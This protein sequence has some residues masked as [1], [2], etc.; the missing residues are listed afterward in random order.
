MASSSG[1]RRLLITDDDHD[2]TERDHPAER[3]GL[4][5][6]DAGGPP[7]SGSSGSPPGPN[8]S[9]VFSH[10]VRLSTLPA[11]AVAIMANAIMIVLVFL[12]PI[13]CEG[14]QSDTKPLELCQL[15]PFSILVYTHAAHWV[16][17][18][19]VDQFLKKEH[20]KSRLRGYIS[21]YLQTVRS[22]T[23]RRR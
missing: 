8:L 18:L 14:R 9:S 15:E 4:D 13:L 23:D 1:D 7:P 6:R 22:K 17:H 11:T 5:G 10:F 19:I 3:A 12:L 20:K 21:F 16:I 2:H